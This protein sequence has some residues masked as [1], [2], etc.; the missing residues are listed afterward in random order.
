[1]SRVLRPLRRFHFDML[2]ER[3]NRDSPREP[4]D[5]MDMVDPRTGSQRMVTDLV[6]MIPRHATHLVSKSVV[7]KESLA[8][9]RTEDHVQ[10]HTSQ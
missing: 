6:D 3:R 5:D 8:V 4:A 9:L 7:Q 10:P 2:N 1:M